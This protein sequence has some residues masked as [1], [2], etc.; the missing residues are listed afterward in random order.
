MA[1]KS[2]LLKMSIL[3]ADDKLS[4]LKFR[5]WLRGEAEDIQSHAHEFDLIIIRLF[6]PEKLMLLLTQRKLDD[7]L[8]GITN[9]LKNIYRIELVAVT[10]SLSAQEMTEAAEEAKVNLAE[11]AKELA[12]I[13]ESETVH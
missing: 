1:D 4:P 3:N 7:I 6:M 13:K 11:M 8:Q 5:G 10:K 9:K 2:G 12:E